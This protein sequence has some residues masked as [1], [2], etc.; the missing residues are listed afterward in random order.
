MSP[1]APRLCCVRSRSVTGRKPMGDFSPIPDA[2]SA[3]QLDNSRNAFEASIPICAARDKYMGV[4]LSFERAI[5]APG[6]DNQQSPIHLNTR[7]R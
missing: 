6:R 4:G 7:K 3:R 5:E 2:S 1:S